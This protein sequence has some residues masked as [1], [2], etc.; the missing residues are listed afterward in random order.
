MQWFLADME[1]NYGCQNEQQTIYA[2]E[3]QSIITLLHCTANT[4]IKY[5]FS[6]VR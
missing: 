2:I 3:Q 1:Y 6:S 5:P 4:C